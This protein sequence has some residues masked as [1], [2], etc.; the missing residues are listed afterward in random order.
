MD[1]MSVSPNQTPGISLPPPV[2]E[3]APTPVD[4]Q[5]TASQTP[6]QGPAAAPETASRVAMGQPA[7][8]QPAQASTPIP[9][10]PQT[11]QPDDTSTT[12]TATTPITDNDDIEKEWVNRAKQIVER[13]RND[14]YRQSE[15]LTLV[16]ADYMKQRYNKIIKVSK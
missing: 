8:G 10:P 6:E 11:S 4:G 14:P 12:P 2:A 15:E 5:E 1:N 16:K 7:A 3:R 9:I 13:T